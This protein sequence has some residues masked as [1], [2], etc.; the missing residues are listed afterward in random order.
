MRKLILIPIVHTPEEMG[1]AAQSLQ[2]IEIE[3]VGKERWEE[4]VRKIRNFW[5]EVEE[6]LNR[7]KL[8]YKKVRVYQ[9]GL[10]NTSEELIKKIVDQTAEKGSINYQIVKKLID[11]GAKIEGTEDTQLL[12]AEFNHVKKLIEAKSGTEKKKAMEEYDKAKKDLID[13]RDGFIGKRIDETLKD[14][15]VGIL[16]I[17]AHHNVKAKLPKDIIVKNL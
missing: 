13:R 17:G 3:K 16:F 7:L 6:A 12:L 11:R 2:K 8:D 14:G 1:S 9:D 15:E 5:K 4:N 10:P